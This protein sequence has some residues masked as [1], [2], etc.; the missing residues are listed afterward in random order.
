MNHLLDEFIGQLLESENVLNLGCEVGAGSTVKFIF[1][2]KHLYCS[3]ELKKCQAHRS[4][5]QDESAITQ[6]FIVTRFRM[7][8]N[9]PGLDRFSIGL[10]IKRTIAVLESPGITNR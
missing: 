7:A 1:S 4:G 9:I 2:W 5:N 10:S 6:Q 3:P 8:V